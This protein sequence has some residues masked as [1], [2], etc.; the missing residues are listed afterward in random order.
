MNSESVGWAAFFDRHAPEYE[1]N[2]FTHHTLR[3][4]DFLTE[5]LAIAPPAAVLDVGC[6]T[7]R[8]AIELARRGFDVTGVDISGGMLEQARTRAAQAGVAVAW[9]QADARHFHLPGRFDAAVCLCEG[10]FGLLSGAEDPIAQ[11]RAILA[12]T[13]A[14]LKPGAGCLFT[15]LN[16]YAMARRYSADDVRNG[17]FDPLTLTERSECQVPGG[18][19]EGAMA[20]GLRERGFVPTELVLLFTASGLNV[21]HI[22]GGTAGNWGPR[23]VDLDEIEI[24]VVARKPAPVP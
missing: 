13:A 10:A 8:H 18:G 6:G 24:M 2:A 7:G 5:V 12:N 17:T 16:G 15:V 21:A 1:R 22:W 3:E 9:V 23:P 11:P 4:V 20:I 14:A 19:G